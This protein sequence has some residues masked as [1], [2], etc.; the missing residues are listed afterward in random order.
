MGSS[1]GGHMGAELGEEEAVLSIAR[2]RT[3]LNISQALA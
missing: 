2:E 1:I 3:M